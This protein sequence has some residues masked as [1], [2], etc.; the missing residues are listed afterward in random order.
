MTGCILCHSSLWTKG[1]VSMATVVVN[2]LLVIVKDQSTQMV[3]QNMHTKL[4][5]IDRPRCEIGLI[6][7]EKTPM[8][9]EV[10]CFQMLDFGTSKS[11][12]EVSESNLWKI[13]SF[14]KT[15]PLQR[16]PFLT[17]FYTINLSPLLVTKK[18]FALK[19]PHLG[20]G[21]RETRELCSV[22]PCG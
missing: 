17:M 15:M 14:S 16:E 11:N 8:S 21:V 2:Q 20:R 22:C 6:M 1:K 4:S 12:S 9:H 19:S 13:T 7:K 3:S 5:S 18:G 10:V